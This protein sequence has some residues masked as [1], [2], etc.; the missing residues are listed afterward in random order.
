MYYPFGLGPRGCLGK[1]LALAELGSLLIALSR[2]TG[3][4][5]FL[6][7]ESMDVQWQPLP[8][9]APS[10]GLPVRLDPRSG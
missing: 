2:Q 7:T 9:P 5:E 6:G 4:G 8:F 10:D 1:H 3:G